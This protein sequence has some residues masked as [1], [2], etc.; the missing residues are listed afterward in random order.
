MQD[1]CTLHCDAIV[2]Y[3]VHS[4]TQLE[5]APPACFREDFAAK[6]AFRLLHQY[7]QKV[8]EWFFVIQVP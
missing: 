6:N 1:T 4:D 5:T 2:L 3:A 8:L 7:Q